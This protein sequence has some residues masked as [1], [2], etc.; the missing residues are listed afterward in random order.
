MAWTSMSIGSSRN[1][2]VRTRAEA[3]IPEESAAQAEFSADY[4]R[5]SAYEAQVASDRAHADAL[6]AGKSATEAEKDATAAWKDV[7]AKRQAEEAEA[8]RVAAEKREKE[9]ESKP[10]CHIPMNRDSLPPCALAGHELVFPTIDPTIKEFA[11][12]VLGL[13]D[14]KDCAKNPSLGKCA[15]A[16]LGF[17][18]VGK[19]K[20]LKK[21]VEGVEGAI[22]SSRAARLAQDCVKCFLAGTKVL[23]ADDSV[24]NIE[25]IHVG[26]QVLATD[27]AT[28]ETGPRRVT[29]LIVTEGD[30]Y[31]VDLTISTPRGEKKLTATEEHP[32]W[33]PSEDEWV[34]AWALDS[35]MTLRTND[36]E[37]VTVR[38]NRFYSQSA[39]T[40][41][42]TVEGLHSY[43]VLAGDTPVLVHNSRCLIGNI[44]GPK[45]ET[46]WL[47]K[48]R[49]AIATANNLKGWFYDIKASEAVANGFHKTV[50]YVRVMDPTTSGPHPYPNGYISY[51]NEAGQIINPIT[52]KTVTKSDPYWHIAIP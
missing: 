39:R 30:K 28:G 19:V 15:L 34:E 37:T 12:E 26:D 25:S 33:S 44:V 14:A 45:G 40:H 18:P 49:K 43:Y 5:T 7:V 3:G 38:A 2:G 21:A 1:S 11:W 27:P 50:R 48:G 24:A 6:A 23:M 35:G 22:D 32:F 46:L 51:L 47:P 42:L 41:N 36:G 9:R 17:L 16:A 4:A 13:N 52:G 29:D 10:K 31:F 20:L 8:R